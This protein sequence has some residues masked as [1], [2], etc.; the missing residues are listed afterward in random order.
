MSKKQKYSQ[1]NDNVHQLT[2]WDQQDD[3]Q[4]SMGDQDLAESS[5]DIDDDKSKRELI[6]LKLSLA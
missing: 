3:Y 4:D 5:R 6:T 2:I 1:N